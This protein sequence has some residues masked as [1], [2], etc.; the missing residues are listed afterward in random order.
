MEILFNC[1]CRSPLIFP[2]ILQ[3]DGKEGRVKG[4]VVR[5]FS[6]FKNSVCFTNTQTGTQIHNHVFSQTQLYGHFFGSLIL[7]SSVKWFRGV[8]S[9]KHLT[10]I[11]IFDENDINQHARFCKHILSRSV[12]YMGFHGPL[13]LFQI[14]A[15]SVPCSCLLRQETSLWTELEQLEQ[16]T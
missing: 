8:V 14:L 15:T 1:P 7:I 9:F 6:Q 12:L 5:T 3:Q 10:A 2:T 4:V 13:A 11:V 16:S